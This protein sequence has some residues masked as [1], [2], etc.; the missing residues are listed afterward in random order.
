MNTKPPAVEPDR[1]SVRTG[2]GHRTTISIPE[3]VHLQYVQDFGGAGRFRKNLND[4]IREATPR[5]GLT[6]SMAVR[7]LLDKRLGR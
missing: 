1:L 4:V 7:L 6:R 5:P 3:S 2:T